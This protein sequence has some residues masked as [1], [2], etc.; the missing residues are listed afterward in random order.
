MAER[1][2]QVNLVE[3]ED[4]APANALP[5]AGSRGSRD[6]RTKLGDEV[7]DVRPL[8]A[9]RVQLQVSRAFD[10]GGNALELC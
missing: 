10:A 1:Y 5:I 6:R 7:I 4:A 8:D 2:S 9:I 3:R